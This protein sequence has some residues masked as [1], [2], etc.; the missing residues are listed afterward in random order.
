MCCK[1]A[2]KVRS[3]AFLRGLVTWLCN[4]TIPCFFFSL[5]P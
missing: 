4:A 1:V 2:E 3:S 5:I